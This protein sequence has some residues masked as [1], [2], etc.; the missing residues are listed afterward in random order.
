[1]FFN[2]WNACLITQENSSRPL[3]TDMG[4]KCQNN[5]VALED[6]YPKQWADKV[7]I[8]DWARI[9]VLNDSTFDYKSAILSELLP[10]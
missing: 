1:M 10:Y 8:P 9:D 6:G 4:T 3:Y 2:I 5:S 7:A